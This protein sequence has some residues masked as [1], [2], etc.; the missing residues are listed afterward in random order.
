MADNQ[1]DLDFA[2]A[3]EELAALDDKPI[4]ADFNAPAAEAPAAEAPAA[5]AAEA[6]AAPAAE[7][8]GI[9]AT[10]GAVEK[11]AE[12]APAA[13]APEPAPRQ[14]DDDLINRLAKAVKEQVVQPE[15]QAQPQAQPEPEL[16][17]DE[18]KKI[19]DTYVKDWPD[20]AKAEA[21][22]RRAEY[23]QLAQYMFAQVAQHLQPLTQVV[24][25]LSER[26]Q[27]GDLRQEVSDYDDIRDKVVEWV[28][29]QPAYLQPAY[30]QVVQRGTP[31]EV[32]DLINRFKQDTGY[33]APTAQAVPAAPATPAPKPQNPALKQAAAALAPVRSQRT[34]PAQA[35]PVTFEDAFKMFAEKN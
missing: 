10:P 28:G 3:F 33:T 29:K 24:Q 22:V 32:V 5:P 11:T 20:V 14:A 9:V 12:A 18:E 8:E 35:E 27:L 21:L 1:N 19:L 2:K 4:P 17:N 25:T 31:E 6:P 26:T 23:R 34:A 30:A 15:P 7:E 16:Y 13:P